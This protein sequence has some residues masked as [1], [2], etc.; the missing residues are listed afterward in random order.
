M[1]IKKVSQLV[2]LSSDTI[3]YYEK[4]GLLPKVKRN[5]SGFRDFKEDDIARLKFITCFRNAGISIERLT[6][7][8]KLVDKGPETISDRI[9]ILETEKEKLIKKQTELDNAIKTLDF[10]IKNYKESIESIEEHLFY[11]TD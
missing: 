9:H 2:S 11:S 10:K 1:N 5:H 6:E 3:R 8:L 4:I 7:Y